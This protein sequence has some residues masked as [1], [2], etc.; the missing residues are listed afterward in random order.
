MPATSA[1]SLGDTRPRIA[2]FDYFVTRTSPSGNCWL[3]LLRQLA[4]SFDFTVF[5]V[6]F[7]NPRPSRIR[8]VRVPVWFRRP[9]GALFVCFH[10]TALLA[11]LIEKARGRN[12][13]L[14]LSVESNFL[15]PNIC[16]AHFCHRYYIETRF[17]QSGRRGMHRLARWVNHALRAAIEPF[18]FRRAR[19]I[20]TPSAGLARELAQ[21]YPAAA[22]KLTVVPNA[23]PP[24][25]APSPEFDRWEF[26]RRL[27]LEASD[28]AIAFVALGDFEAKGLG[29]LLQALREL[30]ERRLKVLVV[31]GTWDAIREAR[32]KAKSLDVAAQ[33]VCVGFQMDVR[34]YLWSSDALALLSSYE[35]FP[36]V[37]LEAAAA[38]LPL[39]VTPVHGVADFVCPGRNAIVVER[40]PSAVARGLRI[41]LELGPH[42]RAAMGSAAY[43]TVRAYSQD[44]LAA[45]WAAVLTRQLE[46]RS[47]AGAAAAQL[48]HP[49]A[50]PTH[51]P[52]D[53]AKLTDHAHPPGTTRHGN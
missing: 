29:V 9:L 43:H 21:V 37:V 5:A 38:H 1:N 33:L 4:D 44:A 6:E 19:E 50:R 11:Y 13:D 45:A 52:I 24:D 47:L 41:L 31:G 14:V 27:G 12:F 28:V 26:R 18:V 53:A 8:W 32:S 49:T 25:F 46:H 23:I 10:V 7:D 16:Y 40:T 15:L 42:G 3:G 20:V 2:I 30:G 36:L 22:P 39:L 34:P 48:R 51:I 17:S 35:V